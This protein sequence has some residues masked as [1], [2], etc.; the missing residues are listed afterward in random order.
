MMT[1]YVYIKQLSCCV[2]VACHWLVSTIITNFKSCDG[3]RIVKLLLYSTI[4]DEH[5]PNIY[6][7]DTCWLGFM[8]VIS[9][10]DFKKSTAAGLPVAPSE[11]L[12]VDADTP[13]LDA[14][15]LEAVIENSR[16]DS[17]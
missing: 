10:R 5:E 12:E 9:G 3:A 7:E 17:D 4:C 14:L 2:H 16:D 13:A 6:L 11:S 15:C 1:T 8:Y